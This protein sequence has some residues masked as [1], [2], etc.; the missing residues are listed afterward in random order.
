MV[1]R[2]GVVLVLFAEVG[3]MSGAAGC[4]KEGKE[5][6]VIPFFDSE[7]PC[8]V[9]AVVRDNCQRCHA[10]QPLFGAPMALTSA[11]AFRSVR[12]AEDPRPVFDVALERIQSAA[13]PMPPEPFML[14]DADRAMLVDWLTSGAPDKATGT[15]DPPPAIPPSMPAKTCAGGSE[16]YRAHAPGA[17]DEA[18]VIPA[19]AENGGDVTMCFTFA[20]APA[21][22]AL[23]TSW[24]P[25]LDNESVLHH[26][27]LYAISGPVTDGDVA[28]CR[29]QGA[30][31]L[32]GWEPGRPNTTLPDDI[33]LELPTAADSGFLLEVHYHTHMG[34]N[35]VDR[36]GMHFCTTSS[37]RPFT[38]GVL[39]LGTDNVLVLPGQN[40][41]AT[42][43]C[44]S[45][46]TSGLSGPLHVISS[47]PHMHQ[48][49]RSLTSDIVHP[50]GSITPLVDLPSW[51]PHQQPLLIHA[52]V[53]DI[54]PGDSIRTTCTYGDPNDHVVM[55]GPRASDEMC[56]SYNLVYPIT[57]LPQRLAEAP[58][59]LCDCPPGE[60]CDL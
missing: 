25:V 20:R 16:V 10:E 34:G 53:I 44:P 8:K 39:T 1:C 58:L 45:A 57:A 52:P 43:N 37:P 29:I 26:M 48:L 17:P 27:N 46:V 60:S 13:R 4:G 6:V 12:S 22:D 40:S 18:F 35:Q 33:G 42:G 11:Q 5:G 51:D 54:Q 55:F 32:M 36:S 38:A 50:G 19:V 49:G 2:K 7:I 9:E 15:C 56:Y 3:V 14:A 30:T 31:Y 59:R 28:P 24:E 23:G 47:A 41:R 21:T